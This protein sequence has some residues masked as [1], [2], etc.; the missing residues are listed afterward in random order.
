[1]RGALFS[2]L[3]VLVG[4]AMIGGGVWG[5][6]GD[7]ADD[8]GSS[9]S[10]TV[11]LPRTSSIEECSQVAER[12]KRFRLPRDLTFGPYGR[13]IVKCKGGSV[14]FTLDIDSAELKPTTFYEVVLEKGRREESIGS[15]LTPPSGVD[16]LPTTVTVGPEVRLRRYDFLTVRE[17]PFHAPKDAP[18]AFPL[19]AAL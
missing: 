11:E 5:V 8:D 18:P 17:D 15:M 9:S 3:A 13:A 7:V 4:G 12:D 10:T 6:I 14:A 16:W 2:L 19:S 1:M